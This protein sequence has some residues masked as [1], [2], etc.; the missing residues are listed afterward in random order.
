RCIETAKILEQEIEAAAIIDSALAELKTTAT[1]A[2]YLECWLNIP[3]VKL[4]LEQTIVRLLWRLLYDGNPAT[5][6]AD[7][8]RIDTAIALGQQLRLGLTLDQAQEVYFSCLNQY[9]VP[10][11]LLDA[12]Y[13]QHPSCR[14]DII[15]IRPLLKLG[16]SLAIDVSCWL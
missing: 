8:A 1:E 6:A 16:Q 5:L 15:Q 3:D 13:S 14:W 10:N 11:C 2:N 9:I 7:V 4:I 12:T